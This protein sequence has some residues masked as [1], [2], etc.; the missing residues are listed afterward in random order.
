MQI[1]KHAR[2]EQG[3]EQ[4]EH[5]PPETVPSKAR[6]HQRRVVGPDRAV[7]VGHRVVL[8]LAGRDGSDAPTRKPSR[9]QQR[10]GDPPRVLPTRDPGPQTMTRIRGAHSTRALPTIEGKRVGAQLFA[11]ELA[12]ELLPVLRR[13][14]YKEGRAVLIAKRVGEA[15]SCQAGGIRVSLYLAEGD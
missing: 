2:I 5:V 9:V 13:L 7:V 8:D 14:A 1:G 4:R 3:T 6:C 11:P 10:P 15:G 12:L